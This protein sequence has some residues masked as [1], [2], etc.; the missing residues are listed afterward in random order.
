[1]KLQKENLLLYLITDNRWATDTEPLYKQVEKAVI[2][3]VTI[4]QYREKNQMYFEQA[5]KIKEICKLHN[6]PFI[7]NDN[8]QLA[9]EIDADGVHVGQE[10][11]PVIKARKILG[12]NKII[13]TSAHNVEEAKKAEQN[14]ADYIGVGAV[15][16]SNTKTNVAEMSP[17][18]LKEIASSV[19]IPVVAIGGINENNIDLLQKTGI[20]GVAVISAILAKKDI[21]TS[22]K[23]MRQK[24]RGVVDG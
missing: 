22:A 24:A 13:G 2:S 4:V 3:G 18:L 7:I 23:V 11:M 16:G 17:S 21:E 10:D 9:K 1:M 8:P 20:S 12:E 5:L 14:G 19:S 15:F 6:I